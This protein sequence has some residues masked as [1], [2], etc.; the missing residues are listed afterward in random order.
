MTVAVTGSTGFVG[1][2][3]VRALL[4]RGHTVR[5]LVRDP[6]KARTRLA[7]SNDGRSGTLDLIP[8]D[9]FKRD[10]LVALTQG[11][12]A[13]VH[14]IGIRREFAPD[15]TFQR[16][17]VK[18]TANILDAA[19]TSG[20]AR[21]IHISALGTRPDA[22]SGYFR[23]KWESESLVR[24]SGLDWT[25]LR[26]GL[27]HGPDGEFMQMVKNWSLGRAAPR[28]FLPYF[29]RPVIDKSFPPKP[30][31]FVSASIAP[32]YVEDVAAAVA[33][34]IANPKAVGEIYPL[35]GPEVLDWPTM[36][37]SIRDAIPLARGTNK[38]VIGLPGHLGWIMAMKAKAFG[39]G[40]LLPFGPSEPLMAMEDNLTSTA[41]AKA[42]LGASPVPFTTTMQSYAARI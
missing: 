37:K 24:A 36:L 41:K 30:P 6:D 9:I 29:T 4:A 10:S 15:I 14:A 13:V 31:K 33:E 19:A 35:A 5:A 7:D 20:A 34:A 42:H 11:C 17:H 38:P 39:M 26:P 1:S 23:T 28:A 12:R 32:I 2:H 27:I 3:A 22:N 18:A 40:A 8:G 25:I 21:F 16:H